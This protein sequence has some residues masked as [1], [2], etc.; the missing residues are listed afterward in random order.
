MATID[1]QG[2]NASLETWIMEHG[3]VAALSGCIV[4]WLTV[5][6]AIYFAL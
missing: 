4:F 6:I 3:A 5:G 1:V 2:R